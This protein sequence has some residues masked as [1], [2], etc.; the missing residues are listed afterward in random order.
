MLGN[1]FLHFIKYN[2]GLEKPYSQTTIAEQ[3]TIA[4]YAKGAKNAVEIGVFEGVNTVIIGNALASNGFLYAIDPFFKGK[5]GLCYHEIISKQYVNKNKLTSK[6][7]FISKLSFDVIDDVPEYVDFIFFDGDHSLGGI[8]KDW[9]LFSIK[10]TQGGIIALHDTSIPKHNLTI[11]ELGS[12]H[13][14]NSNIK[15][16]PRFKLIETVDSLNILQKL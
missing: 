8:Q 9:E 11:S 12:Y 14:F 16:D 10:V 15:H 6:V 7:K 3:L 1:A 4:K 5:L 13:F 2:I